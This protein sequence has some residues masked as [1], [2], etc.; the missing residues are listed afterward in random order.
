MIIIIRIIEK[1][2]FAYSAHHIYD[3]LYFIFTDSQT[4]VKNIEEETTAIRTDLKKIQN[5]KKKLAKT[6]A[7]QNNDG[8]KKTDNKYFNAIWLC[9]DRDFKN[10]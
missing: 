8:H 9:D 4:K 5:H 1:Q 2:F 7:Q 10:R 6:K 3:I